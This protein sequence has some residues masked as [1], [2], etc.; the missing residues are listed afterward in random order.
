MRFACVPTVSGSAIRA[1]WLVLVLVLLES[2]ASV[3]FP[4]NQAVCKA[5][6]YLAML[7]LSHPTI[8]H[9]SKQMEGSTYK[10]ERQQHRNNR[11]KAAKKLA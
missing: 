5:R 10:S 8:V 11:V 3:K 4:D 2:S 7:D 9:E 6:A 1:F